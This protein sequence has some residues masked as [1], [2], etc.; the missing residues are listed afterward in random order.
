MI[1]QWTDPSEDDTHVKWAQAGYD[2]MQPH[3][4]GRI[5][6][7]LMGSDQMEDPKQIQAVYG[8]NFG[9]LLDLKQRYDPTNFFRMNQNIKPF[10]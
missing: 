2:A 4:N 6:A 8:V 3:T 5:Y 9:R 1:A 10:G 7:N